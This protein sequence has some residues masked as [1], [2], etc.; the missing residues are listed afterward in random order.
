M[1]GHGRSQQEDPPQQDH[2][3]DD[4]S[5]MTVKDED[6]QQQ[7][8]YKY[9]E[10]EQPLHTGLKVEN[11][12][13]E[14]CYLFNV[15][16]IVN[17]SQ[18]TKQ[19]R[20]FLYYPAVPIVNV[21]DSPPPFVR[22]GARRPVID[23][24]MSIN[25]IGGTKVNYK[26]VKFLSVQSQNEFMVLFLSEAEGL[27]GDRDVNSIHVKPH[28]GI[29]RDGLRG[30]E[31][32]REKKKHDT[33]YKNDC[34]ILVFHDKDILTDTVTVKVHGGKA[35]PPR[36][37]PGLR[38]LFK[39][40]AGE[41]LH[42]TSCVVDDKNQQVLI[43]E[44]C[45]LVDESY[46]RLLNHLDIQQVTDRS[47]LNDLLSSLSANPIQDALEKFDSD[48]LPN[49]IDAIHNL[50][51]TTSCDLR[52]VLEE[53]YGTGIK[54]VLPAEGKQGWVVVWT[55]N[56]PSK[57]R[58]RFQDGVVT[59]VAYT[60]LVLEQTRR[61]SASDKPA[62]QSRQ[63]SSRW[64]Q[65]PPPG[66]TLSK[67]T[68][69]TEMTCFFQL[70]YGRIPQF[71]HDDQNLHEISWFMLWGDMGAP[72]TF[73]KDI[74]PDYIAVGQYYQIVANA[75][76]KKSQPKKRSFRLRKSRSVPQTDPAVEDKKVEL[77]RLEDRFL[78]TSDINAYTSEMF[79]VN[80]FYKLLFYFHSYDEAK[81][82]ALKEEKKHFLGVLD[83]YVAL[84]PENDET[85]IA[86]YKRYKQSPVATTN[87]KMGYPSFF[88]TETE[89]A[90][91]GKI[92]AIRDKNPKEPNSIL[93]WAR[94]FVEKIRK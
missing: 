87:R 29:E 57:F 38:E 78:E 82:E 3:L 59:D 74:Q 8:E 60:Q 50:P 58:E 90:I 91:D 6:F 15:E 48:A 25:Q 28:F 71:I 27:I 62:K 22:L 52:D 36:E 20:T 23:V 68:V 4:T 34:R 41:D 18:T 64:Q 40:H 69:E 65:Y 26:I 30:L 44:H 17:Y 33:V 70:Q 21:Y 5:S 92:K 83:E 14:H 1:Q 2:S 88:N 56:I 45:I 43:T 49:G 75:Q 63:R 9:Q 13:N 85:K 19:G 32:K 55:N 42:F 81:K 67:E 66:D 77:K 46:T 53:M 94:G 89:G 11:W 54:Q 61:Q 24:T 37:M 51:F 79:G 47:T 93:S 10:G 35:S 16:G 73:P 84:L 12:I 86:A 7:G 80:A 31:D 72:N 39:K 76:E